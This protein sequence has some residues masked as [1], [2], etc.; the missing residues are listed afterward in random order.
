[1]IQRLFAGRRIRST[2]AGLVAALVIVGGCGSSTATAVPSA[3]PTATATA[4]PSSS[5][6]APPPSPSFDSSPT[7]IPEGW[8]YA[9][10]DG[11]AAPPE[12]A[13]RLPLAIMI[14]DAIA[15]RPQSGFN[16]ASLVYQAPAD[17]GEDR[18]LVFFQEGTATSIGPVRSARPYFV[19]W[20][21]EY[22][23]L[24]G[25]YGGDAK[26]L[27]QIIPANVTHI[28]NMDALSKGSCPYHRTTDRVSPHN[29]YTNTAD[30]IRCAGLRGYPATVTNLGVRPFRDDI[31][32]ALRPDTE[33]ISIPYHTGLVGYTYDPA[34]NSYLRFVDGKPQ[35]DPA[36]GQQVTARNVVVMFQSVTIDPDSEPGHSRPLVANVGTG[37]AVIF[38]E[39]TAIIGTWK[40]TTNLAMTRFYDGSGK[41]IPFVRGRIF[42]QS[43]GGGT[44]LTYS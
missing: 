1:M 31:A 16:A 13:N 26:T 41:E 18:Y 21:A 37:K 33:T 23:A 7:P 39:G 35:I 42:L 15:A 43:V 4:S 22:K 32:Y 2:A 36:D 11:M 20:A 12:L 10:L 27:K 19:Y 29:G 30:L 3:T 9:A 8:V 28:Y 44:Q 6:T 24:F 5:P 38:V 25:H 34:S 14:D 17:G 40:K